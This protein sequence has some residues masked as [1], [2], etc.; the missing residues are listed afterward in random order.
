MSNFVV[1]L[2]NVNTQIN[3]GSIAS[4]QIYRA[5][6]ILGV[7]VSTGTPSVGDTLQYDGVEWKFVPA[8]EII[9]SAGP[10]GS[11]GPTGSIGPSFTGPTGSVGPTGLEP[12]GSTGATGATGL[13]G[14]SITGPSGPTGFSNYGLQIVGPTGVTVNN[15]TGM[16]FLSEPQLSYIEGSGFRNCW[17]DYV[18]TSVDGPTSTQ[19]GG[20]YG[21]FD[22]VLPNFGRTGI[23]GLVFYSTGTIG[24]P[25]WNGYIGQTRLSVPDPDSSDWTVTP[26]TL[27]NAIGETYLAKARFWIIL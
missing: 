10:T 21:Y 4:R 15:V 12:N 16:T 2:R 5:D 18:Y 26:Y 13:S 20:S 24:V 9:G 6:Q 19:F 3:L 1:S 11:V 8:V 7:P 27:S 17:L 25:E 14:F 22:A 23:N